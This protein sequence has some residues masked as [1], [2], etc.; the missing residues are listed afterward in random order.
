VVVHGRDEVAGVAG[1]RD[2]AMASCRVLPAA[3]MF[4]RLPRFSV[5]G[6]SGDPGLIRF[7]EY[8]A[9]PRPG[10]WQAP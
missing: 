8:A 4:L 9:R 10:G 7:V 2:R 6:Q 1:S 5:I 3:G